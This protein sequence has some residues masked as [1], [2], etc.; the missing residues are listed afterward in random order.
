[1]RDDFAVFI[2]SHGRPDRVATLNTLLKYNY[3]G[4][5][6]IFIDDEDDT[7]DQYYKNFGEDHIIQFSK[8]AMVGTFD[9]FDNFEQRNTV[10]FARNMCFRTARRLGLKY[11]T[12]FDDDYGAFTYRYVDKTDT[13]EFTLKAKQCFNIEPV[14]EAFVEF[15]ETTPARCIAFAQN[16]E[17]MGGV[18]GNVWKTHV[19]RK[20]MNT[21]FF[22]VTDDPKD[23]V[24]FVGRL[25]DDVN[26]YV[27]GGIEGELWFQFARINVCQTVTQSNAGGLTDMYLQFGTYVK[28]FYTCMLSP[29]SVKVGLIGTSYP[30]FHHS[31]NWNYTVPK[32]LNEK[33]KKKN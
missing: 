27:R 22:K 18:E 24:W 14:F 6:Y 15:M 26:T 5:W 8:K 29:S 4:K 13:G 2:L 20:S 3:T 9:L 21:F 33:Y 25:N 30:R 32:L 10:N 16:G 17:M 12:E 7:A 23:D 1:M 19:K 11:F 31:I 28:S